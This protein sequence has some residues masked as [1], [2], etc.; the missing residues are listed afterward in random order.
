MNLIFGCATTLSDNHY[1]ASLKEAIERNYGQDAIVPNTGISSNR[2]GYI[3]DGGKVLGYASDSHLSLIFLGALYKPLPGWN[4]GSPLDDPHATAEYLLSRYRQLGLEFLY[5][6][7]GQYVIVVCHHDENRLILANDHS[8]T[9]VMFCTEI[10]DSLI[11]STNIYSIAEALGGKLEI[12]RS[13]EDFMLIYG[14]LPWNR[15]VYRCDP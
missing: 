3:D 7:C 8:G 6:V 11:F 9:R 4:R 12:D 1:F 14:F 13:L 15:T 5:Q 10:D 2:I